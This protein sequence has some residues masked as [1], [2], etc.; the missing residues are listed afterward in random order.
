MWNW[1]SGFKVAM[2]FHLQ[3]LVKIKIKKQSEL[4][5]K[6]PSKHII[7]FK[8]ALIAFFILGLLIVFS[9]LFLHTN[10]IYLFL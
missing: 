3:P 1:W 10:F 9:Q 5:L 6:G 8:D 2:G 7:T 4:S